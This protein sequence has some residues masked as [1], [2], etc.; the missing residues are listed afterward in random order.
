MKRL[1]FAATALL[2]TA[3]A[4]S[5]GSPNQASALSLHPLVGS[6]E[7]AIVN[8]LCKYGTRDCVNPDPGPKPP[9]VGGAQWPDSG[10]EDPDCKYFRSC[11]TGAPGAWGDPSISRQGSSGTQPVHVGMGSHMYRR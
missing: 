4:L 10:W 7:K 1:S 2:L 9:K 3:G 5:I 6:P 8:V 11:G